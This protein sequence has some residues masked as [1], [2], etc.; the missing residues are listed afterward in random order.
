MLERF[1][2]VV[3]IWV[4]FYV[5]TVGIAVVFQWWDDRR[6]PFVREESWEAGHAGLTA[7][8]DDTD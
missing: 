3:G 8:F 2:L 4:L 1:G 6:H 7:R 5:A